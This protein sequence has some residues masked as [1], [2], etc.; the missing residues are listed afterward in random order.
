MYRTP[1]NLIQFYRV[2]GYFKFDD[3]DGNIICALIN[4]ENQGENGSIAVCMRIERND[5]RGRVNKHLVVS[6]GVKGTFIA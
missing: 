4:I 2:S 5:R 6:G 1:L 3:T